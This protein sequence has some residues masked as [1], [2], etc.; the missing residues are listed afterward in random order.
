H[1][2]TPHRRHRNPAHPPGHRHLAPAGRLLGHHPGPGLRPDPP[3]TRTRPHPGLGHHRLTPRSALDHPPD[4]PHPPRSL[5]RLP[6]GRRP[7]RRPTPPGRRL[8]PPTGRP[9]PHR[10]RERRPRLVRLGRHP[11]SHHRPPPP[12][13]PLRRPPPPPPV[14][15]PGHPLLG[16]PRLP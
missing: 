14:R 4:A 8:H 3:R 9:R 10:A 16:P 2:R 11:R 12:Q 5:A 13:P 1:H 6:P 7:R 15:P